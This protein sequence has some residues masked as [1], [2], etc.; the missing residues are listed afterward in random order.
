MAKI[1][2]SPHQAFMLKMFEDGWGFKMYN[3]RPG[4][5]NTYWSLRRRGLLGHGL[6]V[7]TSTN[8]IAK[9]RLTEKGRKALAQ[10]KEKNND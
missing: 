7:K 3:E 4:S 10:W 6:T 5:W 2:L 9:D 1:N 8:L